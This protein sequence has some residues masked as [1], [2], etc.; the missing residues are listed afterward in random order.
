MNAS[1]G[2]EAK[3]LVLGGTGKTG[4]RIVERFKQRGVAVRVGSRSAAP[5]FDWEDSNTWKDVL[6]GIK[7]VYISFQPDLAV[8]GAVEAVASFTKL[9]VSSGVE[10]LVLLSGRGEEE[11]LES[12]QVVMKSGVKWTIIRSSWFNQNFSEGF[13]LEPIREGHVALPIK[14]VGEPFIDVSDIADI[15][16]AALTDDKHHGQ[17]YDVTGG[18]LLTFRQAMQEISNATG[19]PIEF[20]QISMDEY[21]TGMANAG[22]PSDYISLAKYL[23]EVVLDGRNESLSDGVERALGRKPRDFSEYAREVAATAAWK[24]PELNS[25]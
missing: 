19:N 12:E 16:V 6:R 24:K 11:A 8:H 1:N 22:V 15:A 4:A 17:L 7:S 18:R 10:R 2:S 5:K 21:V 14:E 13:F 23:F 25:K 3:I 20:Q 9:A